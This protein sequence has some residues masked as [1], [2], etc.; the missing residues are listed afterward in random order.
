MILLE[1]SEPSFDEI[2]AYARLGHKYQ[3]DHLLQQALTYLQERFSSK[4]KDWVDPYSDCR[5][6]GPEAIGAVNIA[7]LTG[8][9]SILPTALLI[10]SGLPARTLVRGFTLGN[11][12]M[13]KLSRVDLTLCIEAKGK[14]MRASTDAVICAL[15]PEI[16]E[17]AMGRCRRTQCRRSMR[18]LLYALRSKPN[19]LSTT[20]PFTP[21]A[22]IF[23]SDEV[24]L[25]NSCS[26]KLEGAL[27]KQQ[28]KMWTKLPKLVGVTV[29][30]WD[31]N[32]R[33]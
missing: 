6:R 31:A 11:G 25:C 10:C 17:E 29:K 7:R 12:V 16:T 24:P 33:T 18:E 9:L 2:A 13:E 1:P 30:D 5:F 3:I 21:T 8:C 22:A 28:E 26:V 4:R 15:A 14:L 27:L 19:L 32:V 20:N 23:K